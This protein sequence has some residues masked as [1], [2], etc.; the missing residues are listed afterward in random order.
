MP[1]GCSS[2]TVADF[3]FH[4]EG[5]KASLSNGQ[6]FCLAVPPRPRERIWLE[7]PPSAITCLS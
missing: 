7:L 2:G 3:V 4:L 1:E 5:S 6:F